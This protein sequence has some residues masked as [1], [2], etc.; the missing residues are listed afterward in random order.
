[1]S[2]FSGAPNNSYLIIG[3]GSIG[4]A[5]AAELARCG[6][7]VTIVDKGNAGTGIT[8][9]SY[10]WV[11]ANSKFPASYASLN[12]LGLNAHE[13]WSAEANRSWFHQ[14][15][16]LQLAVN[17]NELGHLEEQVARYLEVG[18]PAELLS[19][20]EIL[21]RE[22]GLRPERVLGGAWFP[23]EGWADTTVMASELL[24]KALT[25]GADFRPYHEV[26]E[27]TG[28]GALVANARGERIEL[29]ADVTVLTA[30]NGTLSLAAQ[31]GYKLPILPVVSGGDD[32]EN[33]A[34]STTTIGMT[35]TT[36]PTATAL[37]SL[38]HSSEVSFRPAPNGGV[39]LTDHPTA[40]SWGT[41]RQKLWA[42]PDKLLDKARALYPALQS[43]DIT[44]V[45][46]GY[47]VLPED[48]LTIADWIDD[49]RR[50]FVV[51]THSGIT[52]APYLGGAVAS[53]LL[54]GPRA[55]AL[56]D[57]RLDRFH[58]SQSATH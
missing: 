46:L 49:N 29:F 22:P 8:D 54:G 14:C 11:N 44:A 15:G 23:L 4:L 3:A 21:K 56:M 25:Y 10:A 24:S 38:V 7:N 40:S 53:E 28:E 27:L 36:S 50:H 39:V 57:F 32:E 13:R 19:A 26:L 6:G 47:R 43:V 31:L 48:G 20:S 2:N 42:A 12:L 37:R 5:I 52:L 16:Q 30:G 55:E 58:A 18:H 1:M 51:A 41:D 45:H 33:K 35:C 9:G 17:E 34:R